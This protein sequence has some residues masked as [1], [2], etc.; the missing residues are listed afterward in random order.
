MK[1]NVLFIIDSFEQGGSERQAMQLLTQLHAS[2]K[3]RVHL[4]CLQ[5][6][7]SLRLEADQLGIG[8]IHEYALTSFYDLNFVKQLRR[9]VRFIRENE[10][11]VVHTHCFY[12]N[13]FGMFGGFLAGVRARVT[14]KGETDGFRTPLQKRAE[15]AAFR[16]SHR[17]IA[18]CLVV[19]NQLIREG[20]HPAKIIQ[21]YNGLDLERLK[22]RAGLSREEAL[23]GLS[24]PSD[25]RYIS[26]VANLRNP[27]KDHPMF[28][29]AAARVRAAVPNAGF[30]IAGEGELMEALSELAA[31]LGIRDDVFF[32]G[33]CDNVADLLFASEIGVLSSTAEGFA[34]AIL[35]YMAAGLPVVATDVGGAREAIAEDV[36]GYTVKS[37]DHEEMAVRIIDLLNKPARA[38]ALGEQGKLI[39]AGKFSCDRHL[40]NTLELYDELLSTQKSAPSRI[41]HEWRLNE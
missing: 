11:D 9:L 26:I 8:E 20:V 12:T 7:G 23:A 21:H 3:C 1:P 4:A 10:I 29:R 34:N 6:R 5:N 36:T 18:N 33:R 25:R 39:A 37:G 30:A 14:S 40:Q 19:Q 16:L 17:V 13:I 24:L 15:R 2:G 41:G 22:V 28:L 32:L 31:Q 35:E 38:R 27:V